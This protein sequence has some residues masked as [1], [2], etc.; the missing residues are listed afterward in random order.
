M[1]TPNPIDTA[2]IRLPEELTALT[3]QLARNVHDAWSASRIAEGWTLGPV[4]DDRLK[5]TPCLVP[6]D[7]LPEQERDYDRNTALQT[8]KLILKLG[9]R[10]TKE[11]TELNANAP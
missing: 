2:D 3:E 4:R 5:T 1:Y 8:L 10:I 6:Y 7:E 9:Y 11:E